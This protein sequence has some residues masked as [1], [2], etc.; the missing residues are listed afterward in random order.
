M[1]AALKDAAPSHVINISSDAVYADAPVP[2]DEERPALN[3]WR[4]PGNRISL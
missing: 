1:V 4:A 2:I 3:L